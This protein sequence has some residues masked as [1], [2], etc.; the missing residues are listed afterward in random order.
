MSQRLEEEFVD[1]FRYSDR[2]RMATATAE[3]R[4]VSS[5]TSELYRLLVSGDMAVT[6][7]ANH[8]AKEP[9]RTPP[10]SPAEK[11]ALARA[12]R[13]MA[14]MPLATG[15]AMN[16]V[17]KTV[18]SIP[19]STT[20]RLEATIRLA[21]P[22]IDVALKNGNDVHLLFI[23]ASIGT[24]SQLVEMATNGAC[25]VPGK[26]VHLVA[27]QLSELK[28]LSQ[29]QVMQYLR[30]CSPVVGLGGEGAELSGGLWALARGQSTVHRNR[31]AW[32]AATSEQWNKL[33]NEV[34]RFDG[35]QFLE[36]ISAH[37]DDSPP[38]RGFLQDGSTMVRTTPSVLGRTRRRLDVT[39]DFMLCN[40]EWSELS[41]Y[42]W[43]VSTWC[44]STAAA[45]R[46]PPMA[47]ID[48]A[49]APDELQYDVNV[50]L[51]TL[52][53]LGIGDLL[54]L[55]GVLGP[56]V[57]AGRHGREVLRTVEWH[58]SAEGG[59]GFL[60]LLPE[61]YVRFV[62]SD[63]DRSYTEL[64]SPG[65]STVL[66]S[67]LVLPD[68]DVVLLRFPNLTGA[69]QMDAATEL[70]SRIWKLP[71]KK[72]ALP[73]LNVAAPGARIDTVDNQAIFYTASDSSDALEGLRVKVVFAPGGRKD[74]PTLDTANE[75][76]E[77]IVA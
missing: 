37:S 57:V 10:I 70:G 38:P 34:E 32:R 67:F 56:C 17:T 26:N 29:G 4:M 66:S 12:R 49:V 19:V 47:Y 44:G 41:A 55:R 62:L 53:Q 74:L 8:N 28:A 6:T 3:T 64:T 16:G 13:S 65:P 77:T 52:V 59:A 7:S 1:T 48:K 54:A 69:E 21:Q 72:V 61:A 18:V 39:P 42:S 27:D 46:P 2:L 51:S 25:G 24:A 40:A 71:L 76:F 11:P 15:C 60:T 31:A 75:A 68:D 14:P 5:V 43:H 58:T 63:Y 73:M 30:R 50:V 33:L 45:I 23:G 9:I 36:W 22:T 35:A 20:E